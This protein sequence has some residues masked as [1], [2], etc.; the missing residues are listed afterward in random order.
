M[1]EGELKKEKKKEK[2]KFYKDDK[3][4]LPSKRSSQSS[5][6]SWPTYN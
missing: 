5:W 4:W 1:F 6:G 2:N 3:T